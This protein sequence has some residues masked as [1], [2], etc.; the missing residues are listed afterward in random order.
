MILSKG[1]YSMR[2]LLRQAYLDYT[3]VSVYLLVSLRRLIRYISNIMLLQDVILL[4]IL[5][6][7]LISC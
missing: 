6:I 7:Y 2:K 3:F 4:V 5:I 1:Y